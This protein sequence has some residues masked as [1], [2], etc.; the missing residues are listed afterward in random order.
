[1]VTRAPNVHR[2]VSCDTERRPFPVAMATA[3]VVML[4]AAFALQLAVYGHGGHTAL[5]DLPRVFLHRGIGPGS[6]PYIDRVTE[7][8]VGSGLLLYLAA[9]IAP[10]PMGVL[11]V[12]ALASGGLCVVITVVLERRCGARAWRWAIGTPVLLFA[13]QNWDVFV[14]AATL[15]ALLA[16]ERRRDR[17]AGAAFAIGA[18]IKLFP[19]FLVPPLVALRWAQGDRRGAKRLAGW[20]IAVFTAL[21]LPFIIVNR[22]GWWWPFAFQ[23]RRAATWGSAWHWAYEL[24][25]LP[26]HGH[27]AAGIANVV[28]LTAVAIGLGWLTVRAVRRNLDPVAIAGAGVAIF[29]L[30]NKVYSPTY[31]VWLVPFFVLLPL[32]RRLWLAFCAVDL[33][34]YLTVYGYFHG[35]GTAAFAGTL[36]PFLVLA[37]TLILLRTTLVATRPPRRPRPVVLAEGRGRMSAVASR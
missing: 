6:F 32:G 13:F 16:F 9:V 37:R 11:V 33:A 36:L 7:Y 24:I 22:A 28:S 21:N 34:V 15:G 2:P 5:S 10:S 35:A 20:S 4:I 25:G 12:T 29:L 8:P 3:T 17:A 26:R 19:A 31:D 14:I 1:M 27:E 18:A 30:C 23:S